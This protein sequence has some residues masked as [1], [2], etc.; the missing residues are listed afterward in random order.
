MRVA[1][2]GATGNVGSALLPLLAREPAVETIVGIARRRPR[3]EL[4]GVEWRP[5]NIATD[6]LLPLL[7]GADAVIHLAWLIQPSRDEAT[8]RSTNVEGSRRVFEA[9]ARAGASSIIYASSVGSYSEGPKDRAVDEGWPTGGV[10]TSFYSRHKSEVERYLDAFEPEHA[11][12]RIVRLR[13]GLIFQRPAATGIRRL[14]LGP[15]FP[16]GLLRWGIP[17]VPEVER[18][19]FQAVHAVDVAQAYLLALLGDAR[20]AFNIAADPVLDPE[21]LAGLLDARTVRLGGAPLRAAAKL[22]WWAR[23][24]PS[25]PGWLDMALAVPVMSTARAR[26]HLGWQ[27]RRSAGDAL[28]ELLGGLRDGAGYPTPP[29]DPESSGRFRLDEFRTGLGAASY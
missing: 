29:L 20:G 24:Q 3:I 25:P 16:G 13:P 12:I 27:P 9:A 11:A 19:R 10:Q 17:V 4:T 23:L 28:L 8:L 7:E 22:S 5:A 6:D 21:Q 1:V 15:L 26:E 2:T 14:F 18:L